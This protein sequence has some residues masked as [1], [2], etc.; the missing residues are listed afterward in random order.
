M[1]TNFSACKITRKEDWV[2]LYAKPY[3]FGWEADDRMNEPRSVGSILNF[4][5]FIFDVHLFTRCKS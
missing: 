1:S 4:A 5:T 3:Y 2:D